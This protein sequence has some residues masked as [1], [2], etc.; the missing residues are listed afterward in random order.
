MYQQKLH[1]VRGRNFST[2]SVWRD[3]RTRLGNSEGGRKK[4]LIKFY[5]SVLRLSSSPSFSSHCNLRQ[6][7]AILAPTV[8]LTMLLLLLLLPS[9]GSQKKDWNKRSRFMIIVMKRRTNT[10]TLLLFAAALSPF[11]EKEKMVPGGWREGIVL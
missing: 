10:A 11:S 6:Y 4:I 3:S 8:A 5:T 7:N 2:S 9:Y 1:T